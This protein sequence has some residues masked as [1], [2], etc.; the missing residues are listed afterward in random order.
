[1]RRVFSN[2][3]AALIA[4][5]CLR[6]FFVLKYPADSGDTGLYEQIAANWVKYHRYAM[7]QGGAITPVDIRMPGYPAFLAII[8]WLTGKT[9]AGA[10]FWVMSAQVV[11]DLLTC[12]AI[13]SI[14]AVLVFLAFEIVRPRRVFTAAL[15]MAALCPFIANYVAVPLTETLA[16]FF[17]A[18]TLLFLCLQLLRLRGSTFYVGGMSV[19]MRV[20]AKW[21]GALAGVTAGLGTLCRPETPLLFVVACLVLGWHLLRDGQWSRVIP[22]FGVMALGCILPIVPWAVRNAVILHEVQFLAPKNA[23]LPGEMVPEGFMAWEKT[24]LFQLRDCYLV[25]WK[26]NGEAIRL[27]D[28]P[29]RA[30]DSPE[31]KTRVANLLEKYNQEVTLTPEEDAAFGQIAKERTARHPLR[32]YL[33]VPGARAFMMWMTPRIELLPFSGKVFPLAVAWEEDPVDQSVTVG[34]VVLNTLYL[35]LAAWGVWRLW[36]HPGARLAIALLVGFIVVRTAFLATLETPEPRYVVV[37]F[38]GIIALGAQVFSGRHAN[39]RAA[40]AAGQTALE[41]PV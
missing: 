7:D 10:R 4:G 12:V 3:I 5:A 36:R 19:D 1:M 15:W 26:L 16:T 29:P 35:G 13:A 41:R 20:K 32:R 18:L 21:L 9:G 37:C 23:T 14:A 25:A 38:P 28:I 22:V 24:W 8:D 11:V 17:T 33:W 27:D 31:E 6:F 30:F 39:I 40:N 2:P 34:F